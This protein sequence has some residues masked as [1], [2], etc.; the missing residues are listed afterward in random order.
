MIIF[1]GYIFG[2]FFTLFDKLTDPNKDAEDKGTH[3]RFCETVGEGIDEYFTPTAEQVLP[4]TKIASS[5]LDR[6]IPFIEDDMG[7][8]PE[9]EW[10][11]TLPT[12][13]RRALATVMRR[14]YM[15]RG[16]EKAYK[17]LFGLLGF[18]V[19]LELL[20]VT[21]DNTFDSGQFDTGNFDSGCSA[22]MQY[23]FIITGDKSELTADDYDAIRT[24]I[25]FNNPING[26]PIGFEY[27]GSEGDFNALIVY[28]DDM[29]DLFAG[30]MDAAGVSLSLSGGDLL[31]DGANQGK[32]SID[33]GD[34]MYT[35]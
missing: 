14:L 12:D 19:E 29:G 10:F 13:T 34:L 1:K 30:N 6:Y 21:F 9:W 33:D 4:N 28:V 16:T 32:Y 20:P 18:D 24:F 25:A 7:Y 11:Y 35:A 5:A 27:N 22:C 3:E 15:I 31:I 8:L 26:I 17:V 23:R 2:E